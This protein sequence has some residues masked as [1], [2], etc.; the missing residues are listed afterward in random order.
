MTRRSRGC[1]GRW[2]RSLFNNGRTS[3]HEENTF[4]AAEQFLDLAE[5][6]AND[7]R[8]G[9]PGDSASDTRAEESSSLNISWEGLDLGNESIVNSSFISGA[10]LGDGR[11]QVTFGAFEVVFRATRKKR[12]RKWSQ[13]RQIA[14]K[15]KRT[16]RV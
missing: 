6:I 9:T 16:H 4:I 13:N 3:F 11:F 1:L 7:S 14:K 5:E 15:T 10:E 12:V 2:R 8:G